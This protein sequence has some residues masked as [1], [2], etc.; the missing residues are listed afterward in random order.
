LR[1][2]FFFQVEF[3]AQLNRESGNL[4]ETSSLSDVDDFFPKL[5]PDPDDDADR[6]KT[7]VAISV[8]S[9]AC[10]KTHSMAL[11]DCGLYTWGSSK[12]GQL[13]LGR[14]KLVRIT[15]ILKT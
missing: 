13:G 9:V 6:N 8:L 10:G 14:D 5:G 7:R 15:K 3:F 12:Y 11:T 2:D 1:S 4:G